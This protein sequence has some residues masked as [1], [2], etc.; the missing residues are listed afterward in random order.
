MRNNLFSIIKKEVVAYN[1]S[2]PSSPQ[3]NG[4]TPTPDLV[5]V[6]NDIKSF[7]DKNSTKN[8]INT[9]TNT[10]NLIAK[11]AA[12]EGTLMIEG[13][14][15]VEGKVVGD[16]VALGNIMLEDGGLIEGN[17]KA[18][19]LIVSGVFKGN[20]EISGEC[21]VS[22]TGSVD[23]DLVIN[24]LNVNAGAQVSGNISMY[25]PQATESSPVKLN[26]KARLAVSN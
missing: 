10:M 14:L 8:H 22:S 12:I 24:I 25:E 16:I 17:I 19:A 6:R 18:N 15:K 7:E 9:S 4:Q 26:N 3:A 21:L 2:R 5:K 1:D 23:G 13:D 20:A 11:G